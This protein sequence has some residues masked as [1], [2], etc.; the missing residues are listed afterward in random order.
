MY[1]FILVVLQNTQEQIKLLDT[2]SLFLLP[3]SLAIE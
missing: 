1:V 3:F 2:G